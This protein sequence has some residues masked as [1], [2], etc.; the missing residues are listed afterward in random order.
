MERGLVDGGG[1]DPG[2]PAGHGQAD[3]F[4]DGEACEAA[5]FGG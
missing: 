4:F 5:G 3:G 1:N 2:D